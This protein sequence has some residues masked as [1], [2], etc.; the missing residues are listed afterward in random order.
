MCSHYYFTTNSMCRSFVCSHDSFPPTNFKCIPIQSDLSV[1]TGRLNF[2][3]VLGI[4]NV[5]I[6]FD[7]S[8][9]SPISDSLLVPILLRHFE[10]YT[11]RVHS[12]DVILI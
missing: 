5:P 8:K 2:N 4:L 3:Q 7:A 11:N 9:L 6:Y 12:E 1:D 10:S